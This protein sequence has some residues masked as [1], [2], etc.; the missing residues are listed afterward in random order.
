[1][2]ESLRTTGFI[3]LNGRAGD[4]AIAAKYT[5]VSL[6]WFK[7]C[8]TVGTLVEVL[9]GICRHNF[10]FLKTTHRAGDDRQ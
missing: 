4:C 1:M 7:N 2:S 3:Y 9:T 6:L 8:I 10:F 5:A